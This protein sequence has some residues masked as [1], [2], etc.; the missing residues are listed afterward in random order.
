MVRK[1]VLNTDNLPGYNLFQQDRSS[2]GGGV[3][4]F[5]KDHLQCSVVSTKSVPI[6]FDLL[7]L[8]INISNS[9]LLTVAGCYRPLS[10]PACTL[11]ALSSLLA[12]DTKSEFVLLGELELGHA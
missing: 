4:I 5:T 1:S 2:K 12:L 11:P 7:V 3:A 6:Q 9:S 10:A 8:S